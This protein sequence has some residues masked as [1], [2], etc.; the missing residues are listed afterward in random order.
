VEKGFAFAYW[1]GSAACEEKIKQEMKAT[2][3][4]IPLGQNTGPGKCL[5]CNE[6]AAE[7]AYFARAY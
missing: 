4:C 1:C 5:V 6:A 3:R 7:K 2:L